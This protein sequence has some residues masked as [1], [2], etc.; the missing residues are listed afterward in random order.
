MGNGS[1]SHRHLRL[2]CE[3]GQPMTTL[4]DEPELNVSTTRRRA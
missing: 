1:R 2:L 4:V 3:S